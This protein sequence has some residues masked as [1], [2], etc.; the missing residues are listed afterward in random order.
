[1]NV[2]TLLT[3]D[4]SE[5]PS[6]SAVRAEL[7]VIPMRPGRERRVIRFDRVETLSRGAVV[8]F[9]ARS[10]L[11][12]RDRGVLRLCNVS[13]EVMAFLEKTQL[14]DVIEIYPTLDEALSAS[15][16][17]EEEIEEPARTG[18]P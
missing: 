14:P 16:D 7:E 17:T 9:L 4:L 6:I 3:S 8:M 10:Q 11:L 5:E 12:A 15:W 13:P 2:V 1:M 18:Q